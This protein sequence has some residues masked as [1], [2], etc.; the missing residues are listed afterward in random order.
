MAKKNKNDSSLWRQIFGLFFL[1]LVAGAGVAYW[2]LGTIIKVA[3]EEGGP[4]ITG[5]PVNVNHVLISPLS[6]RGT[7][8]GFRVA[9]PKGFSASHA[10]EVGRVSLGLSVLSLF[11]QKTVIHKIHLHNIALEY[12]GKGTENNL[13][14]LQANVERNTRALSK[15][16]TTASSASAQSGAEQSSQ[17]SKSKHSY[18]IEDFLIKD[19]KVT[20][21]NVLP[22][23]GSKPIEIDLPEIHLKNIS[24]DSGAQVTEELSRQVTAAVNAAVLK[25]L[26][27]ALQGRAQNIL[28]KAKTEGLEKGLQKIKGLFH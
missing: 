20:A 23:M 27:N 21:R 3:V 5:V 12:E 1:F 28:N 18:L 7:I 24:N 8:T 6:G 10:F 26:S 14:V 15:F 17:K 2:K 19:V 16:T 9:N 4:R 13:S 11:R 22:M 25:I